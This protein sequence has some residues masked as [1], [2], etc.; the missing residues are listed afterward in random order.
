LLGQA[1]GQHLGYENERPYLPWVFL[2][3]YELMMFTGFPVALLALAGAARSIRALRVFD[4]RRVDVVSVSLVV[5]LIVLAVSG[6]ARGETGRVW[7]FFAPFI[8]L[9]AA[10]QLRSAGLGGIRLV[11]VTQAATLITLVGF[12]R[13]MDTELKP[14][15]D[16]PPPPNEQASYEMLAAPATFASSVT[17]VGESAVIRADGIDLTLAWR[18]DHQVAKPYYLSALIV[19]PDGQP[20]G[21]AI[22]WQPFDTRYPLTCWKPGQL[23]VETRH[24]PLGRNIPA[25]DYWIS[26]SA[27]DIQDVKGVPV[28]RPGAAPDSQ[29][30]L[31][32]IRAATGN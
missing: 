27:F 19:G 25:G 21:R 2:H 29:V 7:L 8:L 5:T 30:G 24:L 6:T 11:T 1:L 15:P 9:A 31:G 12:L 26:L 3:P 16:M 18:A 14:P 20:V 22:N 4:W 17:L 13:V 10:H 23:V 28:T 32:P